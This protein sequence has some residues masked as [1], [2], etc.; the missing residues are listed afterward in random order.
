MEQAR[1]SDQVMTEIV[2]ANKYAESITTMTTQQKERSQ[3][4]LQIIKEMSSVALANASGA[5]NSHEFSTKLVEVMD[6]FSSL[7]AQFK[8]EE[9]GREVRPE[10]RP[11]A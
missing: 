10:N 5:Q 3:A 9:D 2:K 1:G 4:L 6:G 7:I 11:A 8:V